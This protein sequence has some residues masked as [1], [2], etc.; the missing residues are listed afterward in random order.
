MA[1]NLAGEVKKVAN[2]RVSLSLWLGVTGGLLF[3]AGL[4]FLPLII[5]KALDKRLQDLG[6][7]QIQHSPVTWS[8]HGLGFQFKQLQAMGHDLP[9]IKL[10]E[11]VLLIELRSL[12][13]A[14]VAL[15][16]NSALFS[17][18]VT[19]S[20]TMHLWNG[21]GEIK[22]KLDHLSIGNLFAAMPAAGKYFPEQFPAFEVAGQLEVEATGVWQDKLLTMSITDANIR[23]KHLQLPAAS[24][25]PAITA[26]TIAIK[27]LY[28]SPAGKA[29]SRIEIADIIINNITSPDM[30]LQ[31]TAEVF[32]VS[33]AKV[34]VS[35]TVLLGKNRLNIGALQVLGAQS[36]LGIRSLFRIDDL[37]L[38][39]LQWQADK[40][41]SVALVH[42]SR[43]EVSAEIDEQ[44]RWSDWILWRGALPRIT[45]QKTVGKKEQRQ[46]K[47]FPVSVEKLAIQGI[48]V[49]F[50]DA[51][52]KPVV[53][54]PMVLQNFTAENLLLEKGAAP[55]AWRANGM[56][57]TQGQWQADGE[58]IPFAL[59]QAASGKLHIESL[60][61]SPLSGYVA[62]SYGKGIRSGNLDLNVSVVVAQG[63]L[64][65]EGNLLA[66]KVSLS[67]IKGA[68]PASATMIPLG[69]AWDV[70][71]DGDG[72]VTLQ[73]SSEGKLDD[74][75]FSLSG[76]WDKV[77][78]KAAGKSVMYL[79]AQ[80][81]QPY[82]LVLA[83]GDYLYDQNKRINLKPVPSS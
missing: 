63:V 78:S 11:T 65:A 75:S 38:Q 29:P 30:A 77:L 53:R 22:A 18:D 36:G 69:S 12:L 70:L 82:A 37:K 28:Y 73:F 64:K 50:S 6:Y 55:V 79:L 60:E 3:A 46:T 81:L 13:A 66:R 34:Q 80:T 44:G 1:E 74:P 35:Q 19:L 15:R 71:K 27:H 39:Q 58:L 32:P 8:E 2:K 47:T 59:Q 40:H 24:T 67:D 52:K 45:E 5:E 61:L 7:Q 10:G 23:V 26:E 83:A 48:K 31:T 56:L 72:N 54:L 25:T 17:G 57:G 51:S 43:G 76:V 41:L 49:K 68:A 42:A 20:T 9:D 16:L 4:Y 33:V 62:Q 14:T 21:Q